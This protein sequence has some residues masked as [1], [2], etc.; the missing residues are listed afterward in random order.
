VN[1]L[2]V[3][4]REL[5]FC[6]RRLLARDGIGGAE[7]PAVNAGARSGDV[8]IREVVLQDL[9]QNDE[10]LMGDMRNRDGNVANVLRGERG[11]LGDGVSQFDA[12]RKQG[13]LKEALPESERIYEAI[14]SNFNPFEIAKDKVDDALFKRHFPMLAPVVG[15]ANT[16]IIPTLEAFVDSEDVATDY[17]ELRLLNNAIQRQVNESLIPY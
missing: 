8:Q 15:W 7:P 9:R 17:N 1:V 14:V 10:I 2:S 16:P 11:T 3:S 13:H 5:T 4:I 6:G 12:L